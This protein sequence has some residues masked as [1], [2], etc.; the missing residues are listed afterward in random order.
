MIALRD[1]QTQIALV[2]IPALMAVLPVRHFGG[3]RPAAGISRVFTLSIPRCTDI[4]QRHLS[5]HDGC[6]FPGAGNQPSAAVEIN[7][8]YKITGHLLGKTV[9]GLVFITKVE[10]MIDFIP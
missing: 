1:G 7:I 10:R 2:Y 6:A 4:L 5:H 8:R 3:N 9:I